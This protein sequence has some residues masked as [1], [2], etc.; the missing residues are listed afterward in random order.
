MWGWNLGIKPAA[1]NENPMKWRGAQF[2][3]AFVF[4]GQMA[5]RASNLDTIGVTLLRTVTTNI[6]GAGIRVAQVEA[7][8]SS[9]DFEV[10][11]NVVGQPTNLFTRSEEH[12][13]EL[14]SPM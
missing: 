5:A 11:P 6:N 14:Q 10:N 9:L 4:L 8:S 1:K 2:L 3:L 12:T 13:S 7:S